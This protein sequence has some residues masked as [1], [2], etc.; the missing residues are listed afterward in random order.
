[1][2]IFICYE[3]VSDIQKYVRRVQNTFETQKVKNFTRQIF[4]DERILL[5]WELSFNRIDVRNALNFHSL[6]NI[7]L[8]QVEKVV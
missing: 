5:K 4:L 8:Y 7:N 3:R 6:K 1:M 2:S